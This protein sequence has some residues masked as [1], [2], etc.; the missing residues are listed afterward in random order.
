M[1]GDPERTACV[2][3]HDYTERSARAAIQRRNSRAGELRWQMLYCTDGKHWH[4]FDRLS[5]DD[6]TEDK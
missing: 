6:T 2:G 4:V 5:T 1:R 3:G